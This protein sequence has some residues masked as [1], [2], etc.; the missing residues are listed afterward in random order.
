MK[1]NKLSISNLLVPIDFSP[2]SLR[3]ISEAQKV[4]RH[5][6][7]VIHLAHVYHQQYSSEFIVPAP[8]AGGSA[9]SFSQQQRDS[10]G[11]QLAEVVRRHDLPATTP[12]HLYEGGSVFHQICRL[13]QAIPVDL[14]VMPTHARNGLKHV[15]LG[16]TA[17]RV[18]QHAPSPVLIVRPQ[19]GNRKN[20]ATDE[21]RGQRRPTILVPIDF[22]PV[23][24]DSLQYALAYAADAGAKVLILHSVDLQAEF[25]NEG[26]G[27][28]RLAD[29]RQTARRDAE[30][31]LHEFLKAAELSGVAFEILIRTGKP[32][33]EICRVA[34]QR[35][36]DLIIIGTHGR[37][38]LKHLVMGSIAEHVVRTAA[39]SVLVVP[40]H[41][42]TR[43]SGLSRAGGR[44]RALPQ[45]SEISWSA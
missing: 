16:S 11:E 35:G 38:G 24:L 30:R 2:L 34:E 12:T 15:V 17:E 44:R 20:G 40:S 27:V 45:E 39:P 18:V 8:S 4:A 33:P 14:I 43:I 22:S 37:T 29:F 25:S 10:L 31:E 9:E 1:N 32:A 41:P 28:Y 21:I 6:G 7:A 26:R 3:A 13:A 23:S 36:I 19:V 5:F 42:K